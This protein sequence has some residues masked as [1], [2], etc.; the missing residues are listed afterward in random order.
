MEPVG[1]LFRGVVPNPVAT[2]FDLT[3]Q[4][5]RSMAVGGTAKDETGAGISFLAITIQGPDGNQ[6]L[7]V[8]FPTE[9]DQAD[10]DAV[11]EVVGSF[12]IVRGA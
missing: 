6:A 12:R 2:E 11:L 5:F 1:S 4:G 9:P 10:L 7:F 3:P 8:R